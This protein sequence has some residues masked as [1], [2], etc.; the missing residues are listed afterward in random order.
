VNAWRKY[1]VMYLAL[2]FGPYDTIVASSPSPYPNCAAPLFQA[3]SL[4]VRA[5]HA[6]P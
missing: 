1:V 4:K 2:L 5:R 6:V 3:L